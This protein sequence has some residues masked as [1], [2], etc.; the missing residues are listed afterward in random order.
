MFYSFCGR[1][2]QA[3][4]DTLSKRKIL[5]PLDTFPSQGQDGKAGASIKPCS[6]VS[7]KYWLFSRVVRRKPF[8]SS[9]HSFMASPHD[10]H[11]LFVL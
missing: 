10:T 1:C 2:V 4:V 8:V 5:A 9:S 3:L 6:E 7:Q 11:N